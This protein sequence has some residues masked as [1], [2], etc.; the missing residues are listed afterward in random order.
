MLLANLYPDL[1]KHYNRNKKVILE[2]KFSQEFFQKNLKVSGLIWESMRQRGKTGTKTERIGRS[3][4]R[5]FSIT[6]V[7]AREEYRNNILTPPRTKPS[8]LREQGNTSW[9]L[10]QK[11]IWYKIVSK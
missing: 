4:F 1:A 8:H 10:I 9:Y 11:Q 6:A 5:F 2:P 3:A 7:G